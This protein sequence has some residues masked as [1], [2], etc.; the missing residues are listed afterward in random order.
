V[1]DEKADGRPAVKGNWEE[2]GERGGNADDKLDENEEDIA[3]HNGEDDGEDNG[4]DNEGR[5]G[6]GK[7]STRERNDGVERRRARLT[8]SEDYIRLR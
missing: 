6:P 1:E 2:V 8:D 4:E 5:D 7:G 3:K